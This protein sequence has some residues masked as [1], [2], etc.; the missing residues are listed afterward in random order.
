[1]E[2]KR[3]SSQ[4]GNEAETT[5]DLKGIRHFYKLID[6]GPQNRQQSIR[7]VENKV[8]SERVL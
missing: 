6:P 4:L 5:T 8:N 2:K 3:S 7:K 1:M